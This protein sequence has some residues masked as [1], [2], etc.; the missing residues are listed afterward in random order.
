MATTRLLQTIAC[1]A[2]FLL[3]TTLDTSAT[4][5][6]C[7]V[8]RK[9]P[10]GFV[11]LRAGPGTHHRIVKRLRPSERLYV[12]TGACRG[13]FCDESR[14][15]VFIE[16]VPGLELRDGP[17]VQGWVRARYINSFSCPEG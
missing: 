4:Q 1:G 13:Q 8:V 17:L 15:W 5:T 10:D 6:Y 14:R 2:L 16:G 3:V 11:A 7:A 9:T 12:D